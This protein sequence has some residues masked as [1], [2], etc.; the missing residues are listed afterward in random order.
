MAGKVEEYPELIKLLQKLPQQKAS[1]R[2]WKSLR[3]MPL[4]GTRYSSNSGQPPET[5]KE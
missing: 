2:L 4:L 1:T 5:I 3:P